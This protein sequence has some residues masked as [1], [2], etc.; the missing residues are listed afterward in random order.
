MRA[1]VAAV[2][3]GPVVERCRSWLLARD[4]GRAPAATFDFVGDPDVWLALAG[5]MAAD[6]TGRPVPRAALVHRRAVGWHR[7]RRMP[8]PCWNLLLVLRAGCA[9]G[10]LEFRDRTVAMP[11]GALFGFDGQ[12]EHRTEPF[13]LEADGY[14]FGITFYCPL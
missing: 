3:G 14:R 11:D 8:Y 12:A 10:G 13:V 7:D 1:D 5:E 4:W 6:L 2:V 9:G